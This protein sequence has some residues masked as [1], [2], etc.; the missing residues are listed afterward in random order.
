MSLGTAFIE[1]QE[2]EFPLDRETIVFGWQR[3]LERT[4]SRIAIL[5]EDGEWSYEQLESLVDAIARRL[6]LAGIGAHDRVGLCVDRS[7]E[8]IASMLA[9]FKINAIFVP[10]DPEYPVDRLAFMVDDAQIQVILGHRQ[11]LKPIGHPILASNV[12]S[13]SGL[14]EQPRTCRE[15]ITCEDLMD[16]HR[17]DE[18]ETLEWADVSGSDLAYIMY[19]SGSTGKP[20]GVQIDHRALA[21]YCDADI[22]VY[23]LTADDRTLQFST[24]CF[25]IAIEEIFP[26]LLTGGSVVIRPRDRSLDRNEL[27]AIVDRFGVTA[28]H[29]ATAYWHQWVDLMVAMN[30]KVP[31]SLRLMIVTGE[32]VSVEHYRRWQSICDQDVLWCNAYGPTEATVSAT[33][34]IP[35]DS[36]DAPN[37]PIGKPLKHYDAYVLDDQFNSLPVGE[38]GS[39]FLGGPALAVGY[40]NRPELTEAAFLTVAVDGVERRIYRTGDLARWMPDGNIDFAGRVDHQ[41]KLGSYRIEPGEIEAAIDGV[42]GVQGSLVSYDEVDGKKF[43]VAY[44]AHGTGA[45]NVEQLAEHLRLALPVYMVPSRYV[46]LE[47]FPKTINGK[48]DRRA[49]PAAATG[50]VPRSDDYVAPRTELEKKLAEIWQDILNLP[51]IGI[52]DDFFAYGGSSLLVVQVI[53]RLTTDLQL[54]LPVRDFFANPTVA[55]SAAHLGRLLQPNGQQLQCAHDAA[56]EA[57][58]RLPIAVPSFYPS[59]NEQLYGVHYQPRANARGQSV[60]LAHSIGHEYTRGYAN[61]QRLAVQLCG[62]GFDVLRFDY[63]STG[64]SSGECSELTSERMLENLVD[65]IEYLRVRTGNVSTSVVGLRLGA[66][67]ASHLPTELVDQLVLWDPVVSGAEFL[68][69]LEQFHAKELTGLYRFN[70]IRRTDV[71]QVGGHRMSDTKRASLQSLEIRSDVSAPVVLLTNRSGESPSERAW[72]ASQDQVHRADDSIF[73]N[74]QRF[75]ISAFS[76]RNSK[77]FI[78]DAL[79]RN[80]SRGDT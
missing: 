59:G 27:S 58:E 38:T 22:D 39:L 5:S 73:W 50:V 9:V 11:Y 15:W 57:R 12:G 13:S 43:L 67:V 35:D 36:F 17:F 60:V 62:R 40:L 8:A 77:R 65:S 79:C 64:N 78:V 7:V 61:L 47:S 25:D 24:L 2:T 49:L 23:Q 30:A 54:E 55:A 29:L 45:I 63:A 6:V 52:Y 42:S 41:I 53:S 44:V 71:D 1:G 66:T 3:Q 51:R 21:T 68:E 31:A 75:T 18:T 26:P 33:V 34:F 10:L 19:T 74:D 20:K 69:L 80:M 37:M 48:I 14:T 4:P 70:S 76:S 32:K 72:L 46:L 28:I 56:R 16:S